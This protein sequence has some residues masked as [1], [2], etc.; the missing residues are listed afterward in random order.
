V[1]AP[2]PSDRDLDA[3]REQLAAAEE[4]AHAFV[5]ATGWHRE[6]THI[7]VLLREYARRGE[8]EAAAVRLV[9]QWEELA[10]QRGYE[11]DEARADLAQARDRIA[12]LEAVAG[13]ARN[14][15]AHIERRPIE[16][17]QFF[18]FESKLEALLDA[19]AAAVR[20]LGPEPNDG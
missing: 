14:V 2:P 9:R 3:G 5:T 12:A 1:T 8:A 20:A 11:N 13:A 15:G 6:N 17:E 18:S 7:A 10:V 16:A 19:L 4:W